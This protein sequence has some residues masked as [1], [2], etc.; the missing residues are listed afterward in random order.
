MYGTT[1]QDF[2]SCSG[3]IGTLGGAAMDSFKP[4]LVKNAASAAIRHQLR[5]RCKL[6]LLVLEKCHS[7]ELCD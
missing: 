2:R 4:Q 6:M 5:L 7:S 1:R 3:G